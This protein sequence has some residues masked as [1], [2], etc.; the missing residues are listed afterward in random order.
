[1][2]DLETLKTITALGFLAHNVED[3]VDQLGTLSVVTLGP[4]I[5]STGLAKDEV[6]WAEQLAVRTGTNGIHSARFQVDQD[7]A[8]N[9]LATTGFVIVH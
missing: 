2:G 1:M 8:R 9:I 5:A 6:I 3:G 4:V 7:S